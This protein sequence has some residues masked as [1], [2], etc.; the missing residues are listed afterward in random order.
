MLGLIVWVL[1]IWLIK[2]VRGIW[3]GLSA[4]AITAVVGLLSYGM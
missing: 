3:W 1:L 4:M 2:D